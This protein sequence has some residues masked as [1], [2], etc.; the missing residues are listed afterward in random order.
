M[1]G[2]AAIGSAEAVPLC[3]SHLGKICRRLRQDPIGDAKLLILSL[4]CPE[5]ILVCAAQPRSRTSVALRLLVSDTQTVGRTSQLGCNRLKR[6][7]VAAIVATVFLEKQNA[8]LAKFSHVLRGRFF[9]FHGDH[10]LRD[11][12]T[13]KLGAI[14]SPVDGRVRTW[15][16]RD[17]FGAEMP[18]VQKPAI[19]VNEPEAL[20]TATRLGMGVGLLSAPHA[21][22]YLQSGELERL[23]PDWHVD[24]GPISM[25]FASKKLLPAKTRAFVDF[26]S[27][28]FRTL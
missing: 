22:P 26:V 20:C 5:P 8:A 13:S 1:G 24:G 18:A 4:Q 17:S 7:V 3:L 27:E 2:R 23:L 9:L 10:P 16:M 21:A 15:L 28:A 19:Y 12:L 11:L 6:C 25:Y 14:R